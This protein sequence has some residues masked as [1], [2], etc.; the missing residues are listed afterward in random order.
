MT[1]LTRW[2]LASLGFLAVLWLDIRFGHATALAVLLVLLVIIALFGGHGRRAGSG[3][4]PK[5]GVQEAEGG[6]SAGVEGQ[7]EEDAN[8]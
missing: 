2:G 5:P 3:G 6:A 8:G 7:Y 4:A 1:M